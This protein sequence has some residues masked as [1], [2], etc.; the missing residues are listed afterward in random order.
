MAILRYKN[1]IVLLTKSG[2]KSLLAEVEGWG[3][4]GGGGKLD[5]VWVIS[6]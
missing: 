1:N 5:D 6:I 2:L 4:G 3:V